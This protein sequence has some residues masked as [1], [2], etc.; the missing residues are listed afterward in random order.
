MFDATY[1]FLKFMNKLK[2]SYIIS[3]IIIYFYNLYFIYINNFIIIENNRTNDN[4]TYTWNCR[5]NECDYFINMY[6]LNV[7]FFINFYIYLF[8]FI[9]IK[10][11]LYNTKDK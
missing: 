8:F 9:L 6:L 7:F 11:D 5:L 10:K 2:I 1:R 4:I 3:Y